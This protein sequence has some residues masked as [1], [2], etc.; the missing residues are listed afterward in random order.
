MKHLFAL[1]CSVALVGCSID[2][3]D[4]PDVS[5]DVET[6]EDTYS[7]D[8]SSGKYGNV[9]GLY[10][11]NDLQMPALCIPFYLEKGRPPEVQNSDFDNKSNPGDNLMLP[12][13]LEP[14]EHET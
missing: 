1:V 11:D 8:N 5:N 6:V 13:I 7:Y 14:T 9:C 10:W 2:V 3:P 12:V 4:Q